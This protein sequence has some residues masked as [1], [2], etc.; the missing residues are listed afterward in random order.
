MAPNVAPSSE[1]L[2][3]HCSIRESF[4]KTADQL[5]YECC[6]LPVH[7][8]CTRSPVWAFEL[9]LRRGGCCSVDRPQPI[10]CVRLGSQGGFCDPSSADDAGRA[11]ASQLLAEHRAV[12]YPCDRG[13][14]EAFP[15]FAGSFWARPH[16]ARDCSFWQRP[17][18]YQ[19]QACAASK[20]Q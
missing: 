18:T 12:L 2:A 17:H 14:R 9:S 1:R 20:L 7:I 10:D 16:T 4:F 3:I 19:K 8:K 5:G 13:L 15:S 11:P 6:G